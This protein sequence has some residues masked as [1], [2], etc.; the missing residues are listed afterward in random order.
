MEFLPQLFAATFFFMLFVL[1]IGSNVG[2]SICLMTAI[3]DRFKQL[4][5]IRVAVAIAVVQFCIGLLYITEVR[6][7]CLK[8]KYREILNVGTKHFRVANICLIW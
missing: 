6:Q 3:R 8:S 2:M 5:H 4:S 7:N 1:A